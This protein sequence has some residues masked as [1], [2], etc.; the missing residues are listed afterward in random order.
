MIQRTIKQVTE[1]ISV[2]NDYQ[3][4]ENVIISGVCIDTRKL[5]KG[6]LFVPFVGQKIDGHQFVE[7]AIAQGASAALWQKS[8]PN[9]PTHLPILIVDDPLEALQQL[10]KSYRKIEP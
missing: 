6:N 5:E 3:S 4:Y 8:V 7:A 1:M 9:P 2:I 10:A